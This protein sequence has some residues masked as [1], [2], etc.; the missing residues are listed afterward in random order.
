LRPRKGAPKSI[1]SDHKKKTEVHPKLNPRKG[2]L[3]KD[4]QSPPFKHVVP[5]VKDFNS[6]QEYFI[7][8]NE[9]SKINIHVP[10]SE[11]LKTEPFKNSI[12]KVLQPPTSVV[13]SDVIS[14]RDENPSITIG[15]HI[16][17]GFDASP[18]F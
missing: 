2:A 4:H 3:A 12:M 9:L 11:L 15:P 8:E 7:L 5:E 1:T 14:L 6:P 16:E 13:T 10:L 18:P 17:D